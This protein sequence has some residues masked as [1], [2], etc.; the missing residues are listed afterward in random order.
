MI[1][2]LRPAAILCDIIDL[3]QVTLFFLSFGICRF[4]VVFRCLGLI[5]Q[6]LSCFISLSQ[7][8]DPCTQFL[9]SCIGLQVSLL[10]SFLFVFAL[11]S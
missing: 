10:D 6:L 7:C 1:L 2:W 11:V 8:L 3:L 4:L 9:I 5:V